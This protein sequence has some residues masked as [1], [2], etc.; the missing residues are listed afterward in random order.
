[1]ATKIKTP[2]RREIEIDGVAHMVVISDYGVILTVKQHRAGV[3]LSWKQL[4]EM[5]VT[6]APGLASGS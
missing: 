2:L 1:M 6:P 3:G 4:K 5:S